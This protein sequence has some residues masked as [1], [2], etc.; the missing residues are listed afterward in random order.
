MSLDPFTQVYEALWAM[1]EAHTGFTALVKIG[2]RIKHDE[3]KKDPEKKEVSGAALP[4]VRIVDIG[5]TGENIRTSNGL[6]VLETFQIQ[7]STEYRTLY[8]DGHG[9]YPVRYEIMKAFGGHKTALGSIADGST[10]IQCVFRWSEF[11]SGLFNQ[12]L[13]R[14]IEGWVGIMNCEV[15]MWFPN[16]L[17]QPTL[18]VAP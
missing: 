9:L 10:T 5:G 14:S 8:G 12:E 13:T 7:V 16:S 1:L 4:E 15:E 3:G 6:T 17:L 11:T 2:N 18:A